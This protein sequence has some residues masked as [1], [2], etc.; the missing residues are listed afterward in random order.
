ME[1]EATYF[2]GKSARDRAVQLRLEQNQ[3]R[4]AGEDTPETVWPINGLHPIDKP[5]SGQPYR[6]SHDGQ[7]GARLIIRNDVFVEHLLQ[8]SSHLK[9]GYSW[10]DLGHVIG[11]TL[12]GLAGVAALSFAVL[13]FLPDR[14]A[15][16]MPDNWR[17]RLG[18]QM[19]DQLVAGAKQCST[20]PGE[21]AIGKIVARLAD[22]TADFPAISVHIYDMPIMN[23]FA[24]TGGNIVITRELINAASSADEVAGVLAHEVGHVAHLHPEAQIVRLEGLQILS[25]LFTGKSSGSTMGNVAGIAALLTYSRAAERDADVFANEALIKAKIDPVGLRSF[26]EKVVKLEGEVKDQSQTLS[27]L[28]NLFAT[29]PGT[30]D[31]IH[32]LR[33]MPPGEN[34][35]PSMSDAEW[36]ELKKICG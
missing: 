12:G 25:S 34:A 28:G 15:Q 30:E 22:G 8:K 6:L 2:D 20:K 18:K 16:I 33:M 4:F 11:W 9:G 7:P 13:N 14:V 31:R 17:N 23:A 29:H 19:E 27:V 1:I 32:D 21:A 36:K 10:R 5:S 35:T 3:L 26:F 24:V